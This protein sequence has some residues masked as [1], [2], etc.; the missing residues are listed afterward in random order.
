MS[1][2]VEL[3]WHDTKPYGLNFIHG[4]HKMELIPHVFLPSLLIASDLRWA[5]MRAQIAASERRRTL[6]GI[7]PAISYVETQ[8]II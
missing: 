6:A 3:G 5:S 2:R 7:D 8:E 4:L 1:C